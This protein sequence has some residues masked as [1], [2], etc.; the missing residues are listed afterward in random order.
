M[1]MNIIQSYCVN[2]DCYQRNVRQTDCRYSNFQNRGPVGLMLHSVGTPQPNAKVFAD[3][4][5]KSGKDVAVHAVLQADGTV[6]QCLPWNFRGWHAGGQANNTH[7]GVEMTEPDQIRYTGGANFTCSDL[8]TARAQAEGTY[9][10]AVDLF[11]MLCEQFHLDPMRDIIS[12]AEGA[13]KGIAS[14]HGDP[15]HLWRGLSLDYTMD[16]FRKA[17]KDKLETNHKNNHSDNKQEEN[18]MMNREQ[19]LTVMGD[20]YIN[21]FAELPKWAKPEVREMLDAGFINGGTTED[22]DPDDI[23]MLLSDIRCLMAAWRMVKATMAKGA[24]DAVSDALKQCLTALQ[25]GAE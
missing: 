10:T 21:T 4:W 15:E 11:A 16:G 23:H 24:T 8:K 1:G 17:V 20:Q 19:I 9:R 25:K 22:V 18:E 2:N 7:I 5:N 3:G 6:Y 13:K 12:H 14:N